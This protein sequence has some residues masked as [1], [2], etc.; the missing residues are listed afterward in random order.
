MQ[1]FKNIQESDN[2]YGQRCLRCFMK[3]TIISSCEYTFIMFQII[4]I[5]LIIIA[6][7]DIRE[8][9]IPNYLVAGFLVS[10][11]MSLTV[12]HLTTAFMWGLGFVLLKFGLDRLLGRLTLG[13]GDVK[14]IMV[15][16]LWLPWQTSPEFLQAIGLCGTSLGLIYKLFWQKDVFPFAPAL[17]L[18]FLW[19][20]K[21]LQL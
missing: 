10:S 14:L 12:L 15:M 16:G 1:K 20:I 2:H 11:M 17:I 8:Y 19:M 7:Y 21:N 6:V 3:S 9:R 13:W 18:G 5:I 4:V